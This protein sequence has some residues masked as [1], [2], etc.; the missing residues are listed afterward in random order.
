MGTYALNPEWWGKQCLP[1]REIF[2]LRPE[3]WAEINTLGSS[4]TWGAA[5]MKVW[6]G[7]ILKLVP[8]YPTHKKYSIPK[9]NS[10]NNSVGIKKPLITL[11]NT[12]WYMLTVLSNILN[13][14]LFYLQGTMRQHFASTK[15]KLLYIISGLWNSSWFRFSIY[16]LTYTC[17][18]W[19][20][21]F[22]K[23][24]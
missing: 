8:L 17:L 19:F 11:Q 6:M 16:W 15:I 13:V 10:I 4:H 7:A 5:F 9:I 14:N 20:S 1:E 2:K 22:T 21:V 12:L 24:S 3:R 23:K 18:F